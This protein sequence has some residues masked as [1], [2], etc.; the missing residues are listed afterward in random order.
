IDPF[1]GKKVYVADTPEEKQMQRALLQFNRRENHKKVIEALKKCDRT[2]LIGF[3][4]DCLV[5]PYI[6]K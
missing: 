2:D 3:G 5:P 4:A 1:T 6:K